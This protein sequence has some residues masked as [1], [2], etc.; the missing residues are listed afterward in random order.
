VL[1]RAL[2]PIE[3]WECMSVRRKRP[4]L[5]RDLCNGPGK[6]TQALGIDLKQNGCDLTTQ[7]LFVLNR[8]PVADSQVRVSPRIGI[9][10]ATDMLLRYFVKNNDFVSRHAF[11]RD[12]IPYA[13]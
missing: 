9:V 11:N 10:H 4:R 7:P 8:D 2:E 3:G 13:L 6:L 1:I 5:K 12:A